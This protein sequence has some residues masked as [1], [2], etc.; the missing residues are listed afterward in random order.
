ML[1]IIP[2]SFSLFLEN[3]SFHTFCAFADVLVCTFMVSISLIISLIMLSMNR[4]WFRTVLS[5]NDRRKFMK[6]YIHCQHIL[7]PFMDK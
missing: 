1:A 2:H 7:L 5:F 3:V 4:F 6:V